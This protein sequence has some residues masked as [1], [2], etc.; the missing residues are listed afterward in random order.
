MRIYAYIYTYMCI[1]FMMC[2]VNTYCLCILHANYNFEIQI[3]R[4]IFS[5][6]I[7]FIVNYSMCLVYSCKYLLLYRNIFDMFLL[8]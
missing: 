3:V 6:S 8:L 2:S 7:Y 4:H 1:M 5:P